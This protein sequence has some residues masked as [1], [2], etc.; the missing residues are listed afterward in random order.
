MHGDELNVIEIIR[1]LLRL[2]H[3]RTLSRTLL[4]VPIVNVFGFLNE[5]RYLPTGRT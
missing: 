3:P 1:Q 2:I 5:S 4:A